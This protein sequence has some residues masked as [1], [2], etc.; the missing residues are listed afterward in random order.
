MGVGEGESTEAGGLI[1]FF[2]LW[3]GPSLSLSLPWLLVEEDIFV[4]F[5]SGGGGKL[6]SFFTP[7]LLLFL[8]LLAMLVVLL[9]LLLVSVLP[10]DLALALAFELYVAVLLPLALSELFDEVTAGVTFG[11]RM[12]WA[13]LC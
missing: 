8:L 9:S 1:L 11:I 5:L 6:F 3:V 12:E 2:D 4:F 7:P 10:F 13:A